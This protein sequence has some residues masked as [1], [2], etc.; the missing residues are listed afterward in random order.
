VNLA[1]RKKWGKRKERKRQRTVLLVLLMNADATAPLP[2]LFSEPE[3]SETGERRAFELPQSEAGGEVGED[4]V[5]EDGCERGEE[6]GPYVGRGEKLRERTG[7]KGGHFEGVVECAGGRRKRDGGSAVGRGAVGRR[8]TGTAV[9]VS[10]EEKEKKGPRKRKEEGR[11]GG[12]KIRK[13]NGRR[14]VGSPCAE[15]FLSFA[16]LLL[17]ALSSAELRTTSASLLPCRSSPSR[18]FPFA[19]SSPSFSSP[20]TAAADAPPPLPRLCAFYLTPPSLSLSSPS[21][22]A[23]LPLPSCFP[24]PRNFTSHADEPS[25]PPPVSTPSQIP[26]EV[27]RNAPSD[28]SSR[29][30]YRSNQQRRGGGGRVGGC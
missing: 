2:G 15:L 19:F 18:R 14:F 24:T 23:L 8:G 28:S 10:N 29:S 9:R 12:S 26:L 5:D 22:I 17:F 21:L 27:N 16:L 4:D 3:T 30:D 20:L 25:T 7:E 1:G 11:S 6:C 13:T